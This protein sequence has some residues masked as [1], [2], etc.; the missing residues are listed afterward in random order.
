[1][2][3]H[4][5][6]NDWV[7]RTTSAVAKG[8]RAALAVLYEAWFGRSYGL[9]RSITGRDE[10]F[11]LDVVQEAML[12]V[13]RSLPALGTRKQLEAWMTRTVH[14]AALDL[15]RRESRRLRRE[16]SRGS[17]EA[18]TQAGVTNDALAW[19]L[20]R[21]EELPAE[22]RSLLRLRISRGRTLEASG[23]AAGITGNAAHGRVR[24][25]LA[26]LRRL[27]KEEDHDH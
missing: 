9:A 19:V 1:M 10:S 15:L 21:L 18:W 3:E 13:I 2:P 4:A 27:A 7:R 8:D 16:A 5:D 11:C 20:A 25:V 23:A 17:D 6:D 22:D 12:R 26:R 24:R 14:T